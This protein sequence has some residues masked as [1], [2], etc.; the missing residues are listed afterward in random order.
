MKLR[1]LLF[2]LLIGMMCFAGIRAETP[3]LEKSSIITP[4]SISHDMT[5]AVMPVSTVLTSPEHNLNLMI[6]QVVLQDLNLIISDTGI[7]E[8]E[9]HTN[10]EMIRSTPV[11]TFT[12]QFF[13]KPRDGFRRK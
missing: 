10:P 5:D 1:S 9:K 4:E 2:T 8:F 6:E 11:V 13:R 12:K 7:F 3:D